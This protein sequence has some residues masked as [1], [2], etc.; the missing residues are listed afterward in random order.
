MITHVVM[1]RF[2]DR[3]P[4]HLAVCKAKLDSLPSVIDAIESFAVGVDV[5]HGAV[6]WDVVI[7]STFADLEALE[8]Y[9]VH[10]A[11]EDVAAYLRDAATDRASVDFE[12]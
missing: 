4:E 8:R 3:S 9:R 1:Y 10:P 2:G 6:S 5:L 7:V 12:T 11:H